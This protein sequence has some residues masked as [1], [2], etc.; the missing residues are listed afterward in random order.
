MLLMALTKY[1][2]SGW[3]RK[4]VT[5]VTLVTGRHHEHVQMR[6]VSGN[7]ALEDFIVMQQGRDRST[8][9]FTIIHNIGVSRI[10]LP[11]IYALL[12]ACIVVHLLNLDLNLLIVV[13]HD[14]HMLLPVGL[15]PI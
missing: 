5:T 9:R 6:A 12:I 11:L 7:S 13:V 2:R 8:V 1:C 14:C 3:D 10:S 15:I 4:F